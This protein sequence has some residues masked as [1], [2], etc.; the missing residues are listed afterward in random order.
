MRGSKTSRRPVIAKTSTGRDGIPGTS[1][2]ADQAGLRRVGVNTT[3]KATR[4]CWNTIT[5]PRCFGPE[6]HANSEVVG[7]D[8]LD[9]QRVGGRCKVMADSEFDA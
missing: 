6:H 1:Q 7:Q 3:A 5:R 4:G 2:R 8:Y 9:D